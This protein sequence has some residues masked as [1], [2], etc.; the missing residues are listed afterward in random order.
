MLETLLLILSWN[1]PAPEILIEDDGDL[2][3]DWSELAASVSINKSGG[4]AWAI[5]KNRLHGTDIEILRRELEQA[6]K[7]P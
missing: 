5:S 4:V 3:L 1:L 6:G 7:V 2:N